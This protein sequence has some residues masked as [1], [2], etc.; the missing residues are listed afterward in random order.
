ME[1]SIQIYPYM[2]KPNDPVMLDINRDARKPLLVPL[3]NQ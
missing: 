3:F 2:K 1:A